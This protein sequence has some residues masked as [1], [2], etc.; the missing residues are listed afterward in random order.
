MKLLM[1][2]KKL[3]INI[4]TQTR[5]LIYIHID[6]HLTDICLSFLYIFFAS[7]FYFVHES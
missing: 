7:L 2:E 1:F 5:T 3:Y 4:Y 6:I